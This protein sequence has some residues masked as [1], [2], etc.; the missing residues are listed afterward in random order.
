MT[1]NDG[2]FAVVICAA[3]T[4]Q[5]MRGSASHDERKDVNIAPSVQSHRKKEYLPLPNS[6]GLTVLGA[7]VSA[8]TSIPCIKKIIIAVPENGEDD[9]RKALPPELLNGNSP[10]VNFVAGG[11][12]RCSSVFNALRALAVSPSEP[13]SPAKLPANDSTEVNNP[14]YVLIHDGARPW[15]SGSLIDAVIK[16]VKTSN[17]VVPLLPLTET[18]KEYVGSLWGSCI[19]DENNKKHDSSS[20]FI[21]RHLKRNNTGVAQTPQAFAFP[22]ILHAYE[23][24]AES[25]CWGNVEFTDD[26]EVWG[27]FHGQVTAIPGDEKN[28]KITFSADL[29]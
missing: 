29:G 18:P 3:G 10:Y 11:K 5:R 20:V 19:H 4:S 1:G 21:I 13:I 24:A 2:G 16:T 8:F 14:R 9:A 17:A 22:E 7:A 23:K 12:T 28:R 26:A 27:E 15:V 25:E 6:G